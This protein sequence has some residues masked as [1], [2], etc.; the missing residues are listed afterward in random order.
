VPGPALSA[1][2][3]GTW[4][5]VVAL[6]LVNVGAGSTLV[7]QPALARPCT[8]AIAAANAILGAVIIAA[9]MPHFRAMADIRAIVEAMQALRAAGTAGNAHDMGLAI[10]AAVDAY[11]MIFLLAWGLGCLVS[12]LAEAW[13]YSRL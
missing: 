1:V 3:D 9:V 7:V 11:A 2:F 6:A 8:L 4:R 5:L 12:A 10:G 13:R